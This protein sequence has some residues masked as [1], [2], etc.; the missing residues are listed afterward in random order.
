MNRRG[1][2]SGEWSFAR[3]VLPLALI[4][5]AGAVL[6]TSGNDMGLPHADSA[7]SADPDEW[8]PMQVLKGM[9]PRALDF[10]PHYFDNPTLYYYMLGAVF[11]AARAA[12]LV[13]LQPD[14]RFLFQHPEQ[15]ARLLWIGRLLSA[16]FA[17]ASIWLTYRLARRWGL[18]RSGSLLAAALLALHPSFL[19]HGHFM[20]VNPPVTF[21][22]LVTLL[23]LDRWIRRGGLA[24][25]A[26]AGLAAGIAS[27]TK[28]SGLLLAPI[29]LLAGWLRGRTASAPVAP[30]AGASPARAAREVGVAAVCG[31]VAFVL[32]SPYIVLA[33]SEF[34]ARF[35]TWMHALAPPGES[36]RVA[37][38]SDWL[39]A[40]GWVSEVHLA[41]SGPLLVAAALA[42]S[43]LALRRLTP[44][45]GMIVT[46]LALFLVVSLR[47]RYLATDSRFLPMFPLVAL[48]A[49]VALVD[50]VR[51]RRMAGIAAIAAVVLTQVVWVS[52]LLARF[53]GPLPQRLAS[54]WARE[55]L[56]GRQ[57]ILLTGVADYW[58]PDLP[59]R[60][61][62]HRKHPR[63]YERRTQWEFV[64][65]DSFGMPYEQV[66]RARPD[67]VM[68]NVW[69]PK[70][71]RGIEWLDDPDYALVASFPG[72]VR[73]FGRRFHAPLDLYDVDIYILRRRDGGA[74]DSARAEPS[75]KDSTTGSR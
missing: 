31:V 11:T 55:H 35:G 32:G 37:A 62:L 36:A 49:A 25:A 23:L 5:L 56:R 14:E 58:A 16:A 18:E 50:L 71:L 12:H 19:V 44:L 20:T 70:R 45:R 26:L 17:V 2:S 57:R 30:P 33:A 6:L 43:I 48:L 24:P 64:Y 21:W 69:P 47:M 52:A 75:P 3:R 38:S 40:L 9:H 63:D 51:V 8:T 46:L 41:A 67:V 61:L 60:E 13:R 65:P 54:E 34:H 28:Y 66:R 7:Y 73:L 4:M 10:N 53:H 59:L 22:F 15:T 72:K 1:R 42:G 68:V 29:V 39:G 27:S 74:P